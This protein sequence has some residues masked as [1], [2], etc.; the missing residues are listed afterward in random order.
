M[1]KVEFPMAPCTRDRYHMPISDLWFQTI[2]L[3]INQFEKIRNSVSSKLSFKFRNI[4]LMYKGHISIRNYMNMVLICLGYN[5]I[6][7]YS[8]AV[9]INCFREL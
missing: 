3:V 6:S 4:L 8:D 5:H 2:G 1:E 7:F 9:F